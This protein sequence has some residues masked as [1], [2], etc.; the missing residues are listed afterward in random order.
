MRT[1]GEAPESPSKREL[2]D[3]FPPPPGLMLVLVPQVS[4]DKPL[5]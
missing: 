1:N 2:L 5:C 3:K 4:Q